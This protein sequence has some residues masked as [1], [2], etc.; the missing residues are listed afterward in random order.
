MTRTASSTFEYCLVSGAISLWPFSVIRH[1]SRADSG[2]PR[3]I[4][5]HEL[6]L[7]LRFGLTD[8]KA[9]LSWERRDT[10]KLHCD[11][12]LQRKLFDASSGSIASSSRTFDFCDLTEALLYLMGDGNETMVSASVAAIFC[13]RS[14]FLVDRV[15]RV[16]SCARYLRFFCLC[17]YTN[18]IRNLIFSSA[19]MHLSVQRPYPCLGAM[20]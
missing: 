13:V 11:W 14:R 12:R 7:L 1:R 16:V 15:V 18:D 5:F 10:S 9:A 17:S 20:Q 2:T 3:Y 8:A 6:L 4:T 19:T